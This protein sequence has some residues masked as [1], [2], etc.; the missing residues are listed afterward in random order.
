MIH[1]ATLKKAEANGVILTEDEDAK[2]PLRFKA[3]TPSIN[4]ENWGTGPKQALAAAI[5]EKMFGTEY[6]RL[7]VK[8]KGDT[9]LVVFHFDEDENQTDVHECE[10]DDNL[11]D[12]FAEALEAAQELE[13]DV[14]GG[15]DEDD[16]ES[17]GS[18]VKSS[19][20]VIYKERGD[21]ANCGDWLALTL[22]EICHVV[23]EGKKKG[24]F[25]LVRFYTLLEANGVDTSQPVFHKSTNGWQ[26]RARMT[27]RRLLLAKCREQDYLMV[28]SELTGDADEKLKP[29][30]G[31]PTH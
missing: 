24:H 11:E 10:I 29:S 18:V 17:S 23:P 9:G 4:R 16:E 30:G 31:W 25:D 5:L 22:K 3:H 28:P 8:V 21:A 1:H 19:Y 12:A 15:E 26:G 27:G 2:G 20:K 6:P 7:R 14:D 13:L